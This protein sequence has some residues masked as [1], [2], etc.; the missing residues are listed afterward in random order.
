MNRTGG[1]GAAVAMLCCTAVVSAQPSGGP[2]PALVQVDAVRLER[3][4][5]QREVTGEVRAAMRAAL[6]SRE[7]G[8]VV[9]LDAEVGDWM[10]SGQV[11]ARLDDRL[12]RLD[13]ER[14]TASR[15]SRQALVDQRRAQVDKAERDLER[16]TSA[17]RSA[18]ASRTEV[19][20]AETRL[21]EERARLAEAEAD[22]MAARALEQASEKRL[23]DMVI[24]APF[25]GS[26]V[27]KRV[28][29][30]EWVKEGD[31]VVDLVATDAVDV[32]LNVPE[33]FVR[34]LTKPGAT[35]RL[36][37][38]AIGREI[39]APVASVVA[40]GDRLARAFLVRIRVDNRGVPAGEELRPGM[41]VVGLVPT[42][43]AMEALTVHK[44]ALMRNEAGSYV[45][46]DGGGIAA[47]APVEPVY[48]IGQRVVIRSP[49][50]REGMS[51]ITQGNERIVP[52][53]P[54]SIQNRPG[55]E[56]PGAN[57]RSAVREGE[58]S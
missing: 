11:I 47:V 44:D 26:V 7:P 32:Y 21:R 20:D 40:E 57:A 28:E 27:A 18:G 46:F 54:L 1:K 43:E 13:L 16:L 30:G 4:E 41:S 8:L 17:H 53:Q 50:L 58:G 38:A 45:Y 42:G 52:G 34:S 55:G 23:A 33:R 9:E 24:T 29:V 12:H 37:V 56:G 35:A 51:V 3:V 25:A 31:A 10:E 36:R 5:Q 22:L 14:L 6:A 39:E 48:A 2:P 49:V 15:Q 19:D